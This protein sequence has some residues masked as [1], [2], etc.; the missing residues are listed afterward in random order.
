MVEQGVRVGCFAVHRDRRAVR[1]SA[2]SCDWPWQPVA[3]RHS[4]AGFR[5]HSMNSCP[6]GFPRC[7]LIRS[8]ASRCM[9]RTDSGLV[10]YS[11]GPDGI[12]DGGA[13]MDWVKKTGDIVF[14]VRQKPLVSS[15]KK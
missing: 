4:E 11:V 3:F 9:K 8:T 10:L 13:P 14:H 7:R 1:L 5:N 12:D 2:T 6:I 15:G